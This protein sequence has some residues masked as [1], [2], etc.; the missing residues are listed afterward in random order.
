MVNEIKIIA[1]Y[2][3]NNLNKFYFFIKV[4]LQGIKE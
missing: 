3:D 1:D 4:K 2:L